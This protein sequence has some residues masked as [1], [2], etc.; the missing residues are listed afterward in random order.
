MLERLA[1]GPSRCAAA[2]NDW[3]RAERDQTDG[4][5]EDLN[6]Y[7]LAAPAPRSKVADRR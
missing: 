7:L 6:R 3:T 1:T 5:A 2:P 4:L